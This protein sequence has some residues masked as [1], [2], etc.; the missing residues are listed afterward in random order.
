M[1]CEMHSIKY[2]WKYKQLRCILWIAL[3]FAK[4]KK[5]KKTTTHSTHTK[6][7]RYKEVKR[8]NFNMNISR[9]PAE[10]KLI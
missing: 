1:Q 2:R 3:E 4:A 10:K 8:L 6:Q 7:T 5:K 9:A